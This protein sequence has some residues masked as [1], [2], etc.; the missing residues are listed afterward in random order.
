MRA[1]LQ[2]AYVWNFVELI[3]T[4]E[5]STSTNKFVINSSQ[6]NL[7]TLHPEVISLL[8]CI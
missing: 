1:E 8:E 4:V 7:E 6:V 3:V 2:G 5:I